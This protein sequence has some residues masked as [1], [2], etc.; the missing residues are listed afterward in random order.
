MGGEGDDVAV[1]DRVG[2]RATGDQAGDM[3]RIEQQ[4]GANLVGDLPQGS[5]LDDPGVS[6]STSHDQFGSDRPSL[7]AQLVHVDALVAAGQ[8]VGHEVVKLATGV[9][10]RT[11]GQVAAVV[12]AQA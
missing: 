5:R 9:D 4:Q 10:R 7:V 6:R 11:M 2:V 1:W 12:Q 3:S 8:A